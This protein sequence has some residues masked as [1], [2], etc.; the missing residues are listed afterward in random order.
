[1]PAIL[2]TGGLGFI[3]AAYVNRLQATREPG[4]SLAVLDGESYAAEHSQRSG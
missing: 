3:G 2:V 4:W 1:M